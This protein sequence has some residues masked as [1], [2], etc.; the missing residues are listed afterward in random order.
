MFTRNGQAKNC[1][2][3][4]F[5]PAQSNECD[6]QLNNRDSMKYIC[7]HIFF[8]IVFVGLTTAHAANPREE[9]KQL[10][11]QLQSNPSD[12][13]LREKIIRL[14]L[15][16][17]PAPAVPEEAQ[18]RM[19]RGA[20]A[21]KSAKNEDDYKDAVKEFEQAS[22]AA[23]WSGDIYYNL[24]LAQ[25]KAGD[26]ATAARSLKLALMASP[27]SRET[28]T[29]LYEVEY[30]ADKAHPEKERRLAIEGEWGCGKA[31][32]RATKIVIRRG[33]NLQWEM[34]LVQRHDSGAEYPF[35]RT[36]VRLDGDV[37]KAEYYSQEIGRATQEE[38]R[39]GP[40]GTV[41]EARQKD[42]MLQEGPNAQWGSW[43]QWC[44]R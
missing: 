1:A 10:T 24:G 14:V 44:T 25:D 7:K 30:R 42:P 17:R 22:L 35:P 6:A 32:S 19:A 20:A 29:L 5:W 43:S 27:N 23:P 36:N 2:A 31:G 12:T 41:L 34:T 4:Q 28:K 38:Y 37:L 21:F 39:L 3:E 16:M 15:T 26:H 8:A 40:G 11:A 18:R 9:L 33:A 13:A